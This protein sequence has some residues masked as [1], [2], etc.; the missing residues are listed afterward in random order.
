A[1]LDKRI[2]TAILADGA[3]AISDASM[4]VAPGAPRDV[5]AMVNNRPTPDRFTEPG[6]KHVSIGNGDVLIAAITSCTNTSNPGVL[7]APG[8]LARK[9]VERG[10]RVRKHVK[11]SLAPGSRTVTEYL[12][13]AGLLP[14]LE[15]LGFT[16]APSG[17]TTWIVIR[18]A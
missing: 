12:T 10:L 6:G 8:I 7:L 16:V 17:G 11:T 15:Q 1:E 9:A 2:V 4:Q 5:V 13:Q 18:R 14:Y 3:G